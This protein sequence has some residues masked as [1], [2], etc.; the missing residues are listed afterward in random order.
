MMP[1]ERF[2]VGG[3]LGQM[4]RV[5]QNLEP[6]YE[7]CVVDYPDLK[8]FLLPRA[9]ERPKLWNIPSTM[10]RSRIWLKDRSSVEGLWKLWLLSCRTGFAHMQSLTPL[11]ISAMA[12]LQICQGS[13]LA[14]VQGGCT[15]LSDKKQTGPTYC[16]LQQLGTPTPA[17]LHLPV[18]SSLQN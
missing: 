7:T 8:H 5:N 18:N 2:D 13:H 11:S 12:A 9:S 14:G 3:S 10:A 16:S 4:S 1:A 6:R 17:V 15:A